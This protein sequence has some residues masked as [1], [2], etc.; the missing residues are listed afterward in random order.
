M[1][2]TASFIEAHIG[3]ITAE[4]DLV[5]IGFLGKLH[6]VIDDSVG[7][8]PMVGVDNRYILM[9][10]TGRAGGNAR[11]HAQPLEDS[12]GNKTLHLTFVLYAALAA[13][14][15]QRPLQCSLPGHVHS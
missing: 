5:A 13:L 1:L 9:C 7:I 12:A 6:Q 2:E 4:D 15:P 8:H 3:V 14:G 11:T 10:V